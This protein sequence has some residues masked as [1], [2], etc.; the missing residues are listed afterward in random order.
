VLPKSLFMV[1]GKQVACRNGSGSESGI[2]PF[3]AACLLLLLV[4]GVPI[5]L[6]VWVLLSQAATQ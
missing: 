1:A 3:I 4:V 6:V 5:G 2:G